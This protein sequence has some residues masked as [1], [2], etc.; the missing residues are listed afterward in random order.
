MTTW[1]RLYVGRDRWRRA[2]P[3]DMD[4]RE[5]Q[6]RARSRSR[7]RSDDTPFGDDDELLD[8]GCP[9]MPKVFCPPCPCPKKKKKKAK[10]CKPKK[11]KKKRC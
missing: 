10:K 6:M 3:R 1:L 2:Q 4:D 11:K 5:E 8:S 7:C 9:P